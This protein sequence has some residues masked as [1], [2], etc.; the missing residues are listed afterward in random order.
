MSHILMK[1]N[2]PR[3]PRASRRE[4]AMR[5]ALLFFIAL[6]V[7]L[8]AHNAAADSD[9][10]SDGGAKNAEANRKYNDEVLK[11]Y[12][13][14]FGPN[15]FTPSNATTVS[16]QFIPGSKFI[17]ASRCAEC[18]TDAHAQ[19]SESAHRNAFREPFYQKNVKDLISQR[20]IE[21]TRHCEG[22]HNPAALFSGALTKNS[23]IKRPFD[24]DGVSCIA[25]HSVE[26]ATG[27]GVGGYVM[28][29]PALLVKEDGSRL[30][31]DVTNQ[32]ILDDVPSHRRAVMRPLL[33][34]PEFCAGCHKSQVP[35][36]LN[37]YKFLRAFSVGD[38]L[39]M[40][41]FSKES[42]HPFYTRDK[43][44]CNT[45]HMKKEAAP[46]FDVAA[47]EGQLKSHRWAAANT[48]IPFFYKWQEQLD[49]VA[50]LLEADALGV[51]IFALRRK[52]AGGATEEFIAPVNRANFKIAAGDQLT[53]DVVITNKN[54]GHSFPP[55]LRDFYE[56][57]IEFTVADD[58]GKTLYQ[59]GFIKPNGYLDESA[60]NYKTYLVKN[61]GGFNDKHHIWRTK[62]VSQNNQIQSGR[63]DVTRY[64]FR[65]PKDL[66]GA[67]KLTAKLRY[68]RFT[69]VFS[70][71]ALG[72]SVNY[73]IVTM[74]TAEQTLRVGD[75]KAPLAPASPPK[76]VMPDWRRWNNYGI[77]LFDHKQYA[78]SAEA[79]TRAAE[80]DEKYRP[81]AVVNRAMALIEL[82]DYDGAEQLLEAV[83]KANPQNM[84]ALFQQARVLTKR[85]Q[86]EAA[87]ANIRK[88]L[89]AYPRDRLSWQQ[90]GELLKI[91]RDYKSARAAYE[92]I[93]Q[94]DPEDTGSHYNLMLIYR[95]L[96]M[97]EDARREAKIFADQKD[98][99]AALFLASEFLRKNPQMS[100]E[101]VFWHVHD[102]NK[103]QGE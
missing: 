35:K 14:R 58:A 32:Q 83:V 63:S 75:N 2:A 21:F 5:L 7:A 4:R 88:V 18:H 103:G 48:A 87:E 33:K 76:N 57:F 91:K 28:N 60:H 49:A 3:T 29:E 8:L 20:G 39:Q 6:T 45:C 55:E 80:L 95:K 16:G 72:H 47:K 65:V 25:C 69:R 89:E 44:T 26:K 12:D 93:L 46:L 56:A 64:Q 99:P 42:P 36:E 52:S 102:L 81:M 27:R 79:F 23:K 17:A 41:S 67:M 90:L 71:Y 96:G 59:S 73:P 62:I 38:E 92:Q 74:A 97:N 78:L 30:L 82:D 61:D 40:S 66:T 98:D 11:D 1:I 13:F 84:R 19:W 9:A 34:E 37:D 101:S 94:I 50:K 10:K 100:N 31:E 53:A 54:V 43:E 15:P 22:C 70:D 85:G 51:D 68:R 86:L 77:A 24:E